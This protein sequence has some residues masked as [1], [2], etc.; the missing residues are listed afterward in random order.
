M[1]KAGS[2]RMTLRAVL[3]AG[4][5]VALASCNNVLSVDEKAN[6]P[7]PKRLK[8]AMKAKNMGER[9]PILMRIFK[10]DSE[11]EIWK[12]KANGRYALLKT[13]EICKWSGK[14][15]PK[16]KEGDRQAPEGF[17]SV[18]RHQMNPHSKYYLSFNLGFPNRFDRA[19]GRTG[20][21]LMVHG[22]CSSS[23]C[24]SMTDPQMAEIYAL[25]REA[26][27]GGQNSFQVQ[28]YPFRMTAANLA[29]HKASPHIDFWRT[30]KRGHDLFELTKRPP[31]VDVCGRSYQFETASNAAY[32]ANA[33]CPPMTMPATLAASYL[34][35]AKA[36][37]RE[38][39]KL[40]DADTA[41]RLMPVTMEEAL[42]GVRLRKPKPKQ[43]A[44]TPVSGADAEADVPAEKTAPKAA[45]EAALT[46][47]N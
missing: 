46:P 35:K 14:L 37:R 34:S 16:F 15:G 4:C 23:G 31:K 10:Q 6:Q 20:T 39:E 22:D 2:V 41:A 30:L 33:S 3:L 42:P 36:E 28:A 25:A 8:F 43:A 5:A 13:Y 17:Y 38:L 9:S 40:V 24:Y 26:H 45:T 1:G 44:A 11:L 32:R 18:A 29:K 7:L 21:H 19:H 27:K 12:Q 47:V